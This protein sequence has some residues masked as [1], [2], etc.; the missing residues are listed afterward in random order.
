MSS[1]KPVPPAVPCSS[2]D[3]WQ[4]AASEAKPNSGSC[5]IS[6][7]ALCLPTLLLSSPGQTV[8]GWSPSAYFS[9][10]LLMEIQ[11]MGWGS[12]A[13]FPADHPT[14]KWRDWEGYEGGSRGRL[15]SYHRLSFL[16]PSP[17]FLNTS[18]QFFCDCFWP[19]CSDSECSDGW[20]GVS[21]PLLSYQN[22][23]GI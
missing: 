16:L 7:V 1:P 4:L 13:I 2:L 19:Y 14:C 17:C 18:L 8:R 6:P 9:C 21:K 12:F 22:Q 15:A 20:R 5:P 10:L 3:I 23:F 11:S